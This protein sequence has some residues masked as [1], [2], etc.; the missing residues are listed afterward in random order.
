MNYRDAREAIESSIILKDYTP[1]EEYINT[2]SGGIN[3]E[4]DLGQML[5][6]YAVGLS[7]ENHRCPFV[8]QYL[9]ANGANVQYMN[10]RDK[11]HTLLCCAAFHG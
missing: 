5:L 6:R 2:L 8:V 7:Q 9:I 11:F 1:I 3:E 10:I 4:D